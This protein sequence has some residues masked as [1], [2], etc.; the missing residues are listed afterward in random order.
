MKQGKRLI[1]GTS[2]GEIITW[3]SE[4]FD[5]ESGS[6]V[7]RDRVQA[8]AWSN[9]EKYLISGDKQGKIVYSN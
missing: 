6:T 9:F 1:T 7:H 4:R 2:N 3:N 8:M 5:Y